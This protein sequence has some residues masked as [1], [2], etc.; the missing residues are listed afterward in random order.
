VRLYSR[1]YSTPAAKA[2]EITRDGADAIAAPAVGET[3][4]FHLVILGVLLAIGLVI[5]VDGLTQTGLWADESQALYLATGRG[6]AIMNLPR[7][8][9]LRNPPVVGFEKAPGVGHIWTSLGSTVHPPFYFVALR[10]WV[11][12]LGSGDRSI[13]LFSTSF[14]IASIG[15]FF[16]ILRRLSGAWPALAGAAMMTFAPVQIDFSQQ[17]RPYTL[18]TF[19]CLC[20]LAI[21]M[22]IDRRGPSWLRLVLLFAAVFAAAMTHYFALGTI[23]GCAVSGIVLLRGKSRRYALTAIIVALLTFGMVW[24]PIFW[25]T[26]SIAYWWMFPRSFTGLNS[27][28]IYMLDLPQRLLVG[29]MNGMRWPATI[30]FAVI[31]YLLPLVRRGRCLIW[32]FWTLAT[33]AAP[34]SIDLYT[35]TSSPLVGLNKYIFLAAPGIYG[36]VASGVSGRMVSGAVTFA[37]VVFG[38]ARFQSGPD[39]SWGSTWILEDHRN[40]ARFLALHARPDDL[41]ILPAGSIVNNDFSEASLEYFII[42]H[43][44]GPWKCPVMLVTAP[45]DKRTA[46]QFANFRRVW[47]AGGSLDV[48]G[49]LLPGISLM[50]VHAATFMDSVWAIK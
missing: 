17:A 3:R 29:N 27:L 42:E 14:G 6:D 35:S 5:R 23:G 16:M 32:Y 47:V 9:I 36:I 10:I 8:V 11:D 45:V 24:G 19:L 21:L 33:I 30:A 46:K 50:D 44:A 26:R 7:N 18:V 4:W 1:Q 40:Q 41:V 38:I 39:I 48:C 28:W 49:K 15:L 31:V 22:E 20:I 25:S 2:P 12:L 37:A 34:L 13:R 43:Y